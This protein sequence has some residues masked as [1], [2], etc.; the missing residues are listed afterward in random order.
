[1]AP[2]SNSDSDENPDFTFRAGSAGIRSASPRPGRK[3]RATSL[4]GAFLLLLFIGCGQRPS[5][6]DTLEKKPHA[7]TVLRMFV[8]DRIRHADMVERR[9]KAW[10]VRTGAS[11]EITRDAGKPFDIGIVEAAEMPRLVVA[12]AI[13]PVPASYRTVG[14]KLAWDDIAQPYTVRVATWDGKAYG[15]P[16]LGEGQAMAW[17]P[18]PGEAPPDSWEQYVARMERL[19]G[20]SPAG[21]DDRDLE[22]LFYTIAVGYDRKALTQSDFG[23]RTPSEAEFG[24][25][26]AFHYDLVKYE[27]RIAGPAFVHALKLMQRMAKA[28][29]SAAQAVLPLGRLHEAVKESKGQLTVAPL[30]GA[31]YLFDYESGAR[32]EMTPAGALNRMPYLAWGAWL[33]VVG[34]EC[35]HPEAAY[36]FLAD[37]IHPTGAS[38]ELLAAGRYGAGPFRKSHEETRNQKVWLGFGLDK[39]G[40]ENL[41]NAVKLQN[42]ASLVNYRMALRVPDEAEHSKI[43]VAQLRK[44]LDGKATAEE[45]L[46]E[47]AKQWKE[48][49][50]KQP[51]AVRQAWIRHSLGL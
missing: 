17:M 14:G 32:I 28:K 49:D 30:P 25:L 36:D 3:G 46:N 18:Q 12:K 11:V 41:Q 37:F 27:P 48:L 4:S 35:R 45:A 22:R 31:D 23:T 9:A 5:S 8:S 51:P 43:L 38:L 16:L 19:G 39:A 40:T 47:A 29:P 24:K 7:G 42:V 50:A 34:A 10:A 20:A 15:V 6:L 1:M 26:F 44:A 2:E 13:E 21:G 33:G